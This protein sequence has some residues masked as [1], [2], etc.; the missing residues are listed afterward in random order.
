[1]SQAPEAPAGQRPTEAGIV[2]TDFPFQVVSCP[3]C[4]PPLHS[5]KALV[6]CCQTQ[7]SFKRRTWGSKDMRVSSVEQRSPERDQQLH[8]AEQS[9]VCRYHRRAVLSQR[10]LGTPRLFLPSPSPSRFGLN[11]EQVFPTV[12]C[13]ESLAALCR[14]KKESLSLGGWGTWRLHLFIN[15]ASYISDSLS[16]S[17]I[18]NYCLRGGDDT[19]GYFS[20]AKAGP[21]GKT[22]ISVL[23]TRI[24]HFINLVITN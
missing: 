12:P 22:N 5:P 2:I 19:Y 20:F 9:E 1:M 8:E 4:P 23:E 11:L 21:D 14:H 13:M 18:H 7:Q 10:Q 6:K 17:H 24:T 16:F 15:S 3:C